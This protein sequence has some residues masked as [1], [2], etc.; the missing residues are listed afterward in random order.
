MGKVAFGGKSRSTSA[1]SKKIDR[2]EIKKY[3]N[4]RDYGTRSTVDA[5]K[6]DADAYNADRRGRVTDYEKGTALVDAGSLA[7]YHS[8]QSVMLGKIYG[9]ANVDTWEGEKIH[10][11][12]RHLIGREYNAMLKEQETK[13]LLRKNKR[14][15]ATPSKSKATP[16]KTKAKATPKRT[17]TPKAPAKPKAT[18]KGKAKKKK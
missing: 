16:K 6:K 15:K 14:K 9:K 4:P 11:T 7:G 17:A 13:K 10:G 3:F 8:D 5:M 1:E 12:Y 2:D 18:P